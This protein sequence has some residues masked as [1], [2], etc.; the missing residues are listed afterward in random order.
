MICFGNKAEI[1]LARI[2]SAGMVIL[3]ELIF[4]QALYPLCGT[5]SHVMP[6]LACAL[7][8]IYGCG[9]LFVTLFQHYIR[10]QTTTVDYKRLFNGLVLTRVASLHRKGQ[11]HHIMN[12]KPTDNKEIKDFVSIEERILKLVR[13]ASK[14]AWENNRWVILG[15]P[16]P[17]EVK[18][19]NALLGC[20]VTGFQRM[21]D[22]SAVKHSRKKHPNMTEADFC[23]I[24]MIIASA[25]EI[26]LGKY[27]DT[28]V[29]RK[30]LEK[31]YYY[32]ECTRIGRKRLAM[33]TFYKTKIGG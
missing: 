9:L 31:E 17:K 11:K 15:T 3:A 28:V 30:T 5:N 32:V 29:Y 6:M 23:L 1:N 12:A 20:D 8:G 27:H 16:T 7:A 19:L 25:D 22:I 13:E 33:K 24:P 4:W 10:Q 2:S 21:I 26:T 14:T 18:K